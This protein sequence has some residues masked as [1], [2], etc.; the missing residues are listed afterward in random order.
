MCQARDLCDGIVGG[1]RKKGA[2]TARV[3][4]R[5]LEPRLAVLTPQSLAKGLKLLARCL[6]VCMTC[7]VLMGDAWVMVRI[8]GVLMGEHQTMRQVEVECAQ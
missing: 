3:H 6:V 4:V 5:A 7:S 8:G 1:D 2:D